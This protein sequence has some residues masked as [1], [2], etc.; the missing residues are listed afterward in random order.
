[1]PAGVADNVLLLRRVGHRLI[2]DSGQGQ[3]AGVHPER[4]FSRVMH[5]HGP[6]RNRTVQQLMR[7]SRGR[8]RAEVG[9]DKQN[10]IVGMARGESLDPADHTL[11]IVFRS[12]ARFG[13]RQIQPVKLQRAEPHVSVIIGESRNHRSPLKI[14]DF[15]LGGSSAQDLL[16]GSNGINASA[17][18]GQRLRPRSFWIAGVDVSVNQNRVASKQ[19]GPERKIATVRQTLTSRRCASMNRSL[20]GRP[21][22]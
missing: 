4:M 16:V 10:L 12:D 1:M 3:R 14:D 21:A 18:D 2:R 11:G 5:H 15:G 6:V 13:S 8:G 22:D 19:R 7:G 20:I 17:G 9:P